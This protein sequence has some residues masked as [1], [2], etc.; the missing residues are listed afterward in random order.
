MLATVAAFSSING[1]C[2][3][4]KPIAPSSPPRRIMT[5]GKLHR[6]SNEPI[7][8]ARPGKFDSAGA[9]NPTA[10]KLDDGQY[11]MLYRGQDHA[12][13]SRIGY[14]QSTDG[15]HFTQ[16][17]KPVLE[18]Q[19]PDEKNGVEDPR[20]SRS[21]Q[22]P[23]EWLMTAT[24][25][26]TEAQLALYKSGD[27]RKWER[28]GI[29][30]PANKGS[31][32]VHWTKSGAIVPAKINGKY[33]MYYMGDAAGGADQTGLAFSD[34]GVN[35]KDATDKPVLTRRPNMFDSHTVEPGP[36]PIITE[37]GILL[38]YNG[39]DDAVCYRTGWALFDKND[40]TKLIARSDTPIFEP[41]TAWEKKNAT[42]G[43]KQVPNVVFVEGMVKDGN[44][45]LIYYGAADSYV[46]VA[47]T[48]LVPFQL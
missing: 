21:L 41:E 12:G 45:Y 39:A 17:D 8:S 38:L 10:V 44:R 48:K 33:W 11:V 5:F 36:A 29:I 15:I 28:V 40:P 18:P 43:V 20:A 37:D 2:V 4:S 24:A 16:E 27:L 6:L 13:V 31:W 19:F 22:N 26:N 23:K 47:E 34:D 3:W 1:Q 42:D 25:Y 14:A 7:I 46:G 35:W 30:M 32:N 9:F